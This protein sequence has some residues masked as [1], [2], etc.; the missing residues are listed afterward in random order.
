MQVEVVGACIF[1]ANLYIH[2]NAEPLV[3]LTGLHVSQQVI[4]HHNVVS[5]RRLEESQDDTVSCATTTA[6]STK[7]SRRS[8][9]SS[10]SLFMWACDPLHGPDTLA[11]TLI[12]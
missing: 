3:P 9:G 7:R 8:F 10:S 12:F 5:R 4:M 6:S 2:K 1:F 11:W